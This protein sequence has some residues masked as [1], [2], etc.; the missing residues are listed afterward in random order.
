MGDSDKAIREWNWIFFSGL[1][2][3]ISAIA[4]GYQLK[5]LNDLEKLK[6]EIPKV[7]EKPV[8]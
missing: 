2:V 8:Q 7:V 4:F 1:C 6:N 5:G 3:I